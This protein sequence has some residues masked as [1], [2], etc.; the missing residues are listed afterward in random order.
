VRV[1]VE[2]DFTSRLRSP[3]VAARVGLW[4]GV[5]FGICFVTG[6]LSHWSQLALPPVP[7]P[8]SPAWGYRLTQGLHVVTGTAAVPL[9]LVKLWSV[10]PR[11]FARLPSGSLRRLAA[12][13]AERAS[14]GVLVAAALFQLATGLANTAGWYPWPFS[15]RSTH[16]AVAWVAVGALLVHVA[17]KLRRIRRAL[18]SDV[19]DDALDRPAAAATSGL[20]RR[21]L[22]RATWTA[23]A[24][25]VLATAGG[26]V[27]WLREVSVLAVRSGD[28]PQGVPVNKSALAAGVVDTA[29]DAAYRLTIAHGDREVSLSR[30][31]LAALPQATE[32]LP[33]AC[34]EGW[35]ATGA[36]TG[37]RV[38]DLLALVDAPERSDVEVTSLQRSGPF[39]VT[40][41]PAN[42]AADPRSLLAVAL[43][44]EPLALDH[45][46]PCRLVAPNRPGVLQTKWVARLEVR[47]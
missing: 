21:G 43:A 23:A 29:R 19:E 1:P 9:L 17:V 41:L 14:V 7:V 45:G 28:G 12:E 37:V 27:G 33:I 16:Y 13:A 18:R 3:A 11:L 40:T 47:G 5:C 26:T 46:Y 36:W 8:T 35:S 22:L 32:E 24:V 2:G 15:F 31:E 34:V 25:A 30:D 38:R 10:Y 6:L 39:R 42:F 4:L 20:S 44:G